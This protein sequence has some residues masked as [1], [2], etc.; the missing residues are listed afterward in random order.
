MC[1]HIYMIMYVKHTQLFLITVRHHV[2]VTGFCLSPYSQHVLNR[3]AN[4]TKSN[5]NYMNNINISMIYTTTLQ[6]MAFTDVQMYTVTSLFI[7][8]NLVGGN[9]GLEILN[10]E[11]CY[12]RLLRL[13][14]YH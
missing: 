3:R 9:T 13:I 2:P 1:Y 4:M 11:S 7:L 6:N 14:H 5:K 10:T 12:A 8:L